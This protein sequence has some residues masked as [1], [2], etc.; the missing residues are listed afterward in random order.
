LGAFSLVGSL[1][2]GLAFEAIRLRFVGGRGIVV[3]T[4]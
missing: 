2:V 1:E 4:P 3:F